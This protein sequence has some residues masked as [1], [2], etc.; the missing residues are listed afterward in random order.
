MP[1]PAALPSHPRHISSN[2]LST[3]HR[4][5]LLVPVTAKVPATARAQ[6]EVVSSVAALAVAGRSDPLFLGYGLHRSLTS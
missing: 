1:R 3:F 4:A 5:D 6:L 2:Y